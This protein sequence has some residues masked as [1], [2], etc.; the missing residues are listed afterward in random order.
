MLI[1]HPKH[2]QILTEIVTRCRMA[3]MVIYLTELVPDRE[4]GWDARFKAEGHRQAEYELAF[5][6]IVNAVRD[7]FGAR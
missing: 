4:K 7:E 1:D 2:E 5:L 3:G 6:R